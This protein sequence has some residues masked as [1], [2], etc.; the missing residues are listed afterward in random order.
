MSDREDRIR[1]K[2]YAL[3]E[4]DGRPEGRHE[5]HWV[6]AREIVAQEEAGAE[7][8]DSLPLATDTPLPAAPAKPKRGSRTASEPGAA[9]PRRR[10][11]AGTE[12][13]SVQAAPPP[14]APPAR[15]RKRSSG[16]SDASS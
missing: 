4:A 11:S 1:Q 14:S 6:Q 16:T 7:P 5:D 10:K 9:T 8:I 2:A 15:G 3:W 13:G 12:A